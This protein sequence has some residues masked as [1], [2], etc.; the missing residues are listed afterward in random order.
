MSL[1]VGRWGRKLDFMPFLGIDCRKSYMGASLRRCRLFNDTVFAAI[2][3]GFSF[4]EHLMAPFLGTV[5]T[6]TNKIII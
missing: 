2:I 3:C 4:A 1:L 5:I 6:H